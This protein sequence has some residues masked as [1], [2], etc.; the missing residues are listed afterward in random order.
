[1]KIAMFNS[2]SPLREY[3]FKIH[4][5]FLK[6]GYENVDLFYTHYDNLTFNKENIKKIWLT[7][8]PLFRQLLNDLFF[9]PRKIPLD[10]DIYH[11]TNQGCSAYLRK[12][13]KNKKV[14]VTIHDLSPFV[15]NKTGFRNWISRLIIKN[16]RKA[17]MVVTISENTKND[18]IKILGIPKEKIDV[19]YN[20]ISHNIFKVRNK[21]KIRHEL[22]IEDGTKIILHVTVDEPRKNISTIL[23]AVNDLRKKYPKIL[24]VRVG[25][26]RNETEKLIDSFNLRNNMIC[27]GYLN[28]EV[29][30]KWYNAADIFVFPSSF[31]GFGLPPLEA[32]A[33][34]TPV[35]CSNAT[36]L[37]EIIGEA[38]LII[39][40][41]DYVSLSKNIEEVFLNKTLRE[42]LIKKGLKQAKK[43]S[44]EKCAKKYLRIYK[45]L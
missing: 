45:S 6:S 37:K 1:M 25:K 18:V 21:T 16:V 5:E 38:A 44:W 24:F 43:F 32:M 11:L 40:P 8:I 31:E 28:E 42:N 33:S 27:L 30:A 20:G 10:Y 3:A 17:S 41:E 36:S 2:F 7:K 15:A 13:P 19:V 35:I 29:L 39:D 9:T 34:G 12:L 26:H 14:I 22:G 4:D 23:K